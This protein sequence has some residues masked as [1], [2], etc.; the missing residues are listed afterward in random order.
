L[1]QV[2]SPW[3]V[4][5]AVDHAQEGAA[6]AALARDAG[7]IVLAVALQGLFLYAMRMTL[8]STSRR[9]EYELRNDVFGHITR[10]PAS[11]YRNRKVGDLMSRA[12]NDLDAVRDLLGPGIMYSTNTAFTFVLAVFLMCRIDVRLTLL[13]L[14]PLPVLSLLMARM[15]K[16]L[17]HH[18]EAIQAS[19]A[20]L[21]AKAQET[22]AGIR[23]VKAH[24]EEE[25]EL[26]AFRAIHDDY[27]EKNRGMI[28]VMSGMWPSLSLLGGI[29]AAIVLAVGGAAVVSGRITLGEL[30]AFQIYLGMLIWPMVA[31]GWVTNLFQR[32]AAS[33]GR[34]RA[35]MELEAENDVRRDGVRAPTADTAVELQGVGFRY[36]DSDRFVLRGVDFAVRPGEAVAIVGRTGS[37]KTTLL[38]LIARL[39]E[40]TEGR[41]LFGGVPAEQWPRGALRR[42]L[43]I[44][45]QETFLFSE[46]IRANIAFGFEDGTSP[47]DAEQVA[48]RAGLGPDLEQFPQ[49]LDTVLGE[50][51]I[52][53]SGGQK[54][55]VA[56]AR[57][58]AL[59][60]PVLLLDDAFASVDPATEDRILESLFT[61]EQ[62]P[63]ILLATH[64]RSALLRVHRI[65]VLDEGRVVD[66]GS[67]EELITRGGLYA[68]L[69]R[70]EEMVEE[71]ETL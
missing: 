64:R 10:L 40:P 7:L 24:V 26:Q 59:E 55:R 34:I 18:Y 56:L 66:S 49:G 53:L 17:F 46:T 47:P 27:T 19:F 39:Y 36:P 2:W 9:M 25:G 42:R 30:V 54:Q 1:F 68:E 28:R 57:A 58:L 32:G 23:V 8:I 14:V 29:A 5:H 65:I 6:R 20:A 33:M 15:G 62:R 48:R 70:R 52:T 67:H 50:R 69:Y 41:L 37:G 21:T 3:L 31:L 13:A 45:P 12:T 4:R 43:G 44:V 60:R 16:R 11:L 22:L 61:M 35:V 51:G 71:L 63:A 38:Q